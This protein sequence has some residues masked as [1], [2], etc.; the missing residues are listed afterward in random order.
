M[1]RAIIIMLSFFLSIS[2]NSYA[3]EIRV[4]EAIMTDYHSWSLESIELKDDCTL[5]K[6]TVTSLTSETGVYMINTPYLE[7]VLSGRKYYSIGVEG[8]PYKPDM[9]IIH[10]QY[11]SVDFI[12][13]FPPLSNTVKQVHYISSSTFQIKNIKLNKKEISQDMMD[14]FKKASVFLQNKE[15]EKANAIYLTLAENGFFLAQYN[16]ARSYWVGS[17]VPANMVEAAKWAKESAKSGFLEGA[18]M[19]ANL[20]FE[21]IG[22]QKN[23]VES[24]KWML[25]VALSGD[26]TAQCYMGLNYDAGTGVQ[27]NYLEAAKWYKK[28]AEQGNAQAANNL[29]HLYASGKGVEQNYNEAG[30]WFLIAAERGAPNAQYTVGFW[31]RDGLNGWKKNKLEAL[32]WLRKAASLG[33][34]DAKITLAKLGE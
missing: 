30:K 19:Y 29:A 8:I 33:Y 11:G 24:A 3:Q 13:K 7:D 22:T 4:D 20:C 12:V 10:P 17:G 28:A 25:K 31:Y 14:E 34:T 27:Q 15:Y 9:K 6:W 26:A 21:G 23:L 2:Y 32:Q 1:K 18:F 16:L 5:C